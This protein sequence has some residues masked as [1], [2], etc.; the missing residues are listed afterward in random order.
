MLFSETCEILLTNEV[1]LNSRKCQTEKNMRLLGFV[2]IFLLGFP[3]AANEVWNITGNGNFAIEFNDK[4]VHH[5][6]VVDFF[7]RFERVVRRVGRIEESVAGRSLLLIV[8]EKQPSGSCKFAHSRKHRKQVLLLPRDCK[9]LLD[10]PAAGRIIA[11]ALIQSRLG[12][13]PQEPLPAGANWIA[14]GLWAE[15]VQREV[16]GQRVMRFIWLPEL[17]NFVENGGKLHFSSKIL[18]A[19]ENIRPGSAEWTFYC[20]KARL[21][22]ELA[23][24]LGSSSSNL[25]KDYCFLLFARQLSNAECFEQTF[26]S[27]ARRKLFTPLTPQ[28][29]VPED[30]KKAAEYAL[31]RLAV[32]KLYSQYVPMNPGA[33]SAVFEKFCHISFMQNKNMKAD[34]SITDLPL[35]AEKYADCTKLPRIK[36]FELNELTA[37]A[38]AQLRNDFFKLSYQLGQ[39]GSADP[40]VISSAMKNIIASLKR[41]LDELILVDAVLSSMETS[42]LPLLYEQRFFMSENLRQSPLPGNIKSFWDT[43][44]R[45][46]QK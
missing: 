40:E 5:V 34:A 35:L 14:D 20:Q 29:I 30:G 23:Q 42:R 28:E 26:G 41:K 9:S 2:T 13:L 1:I 12:N 31:N 10:S 7:R 25:L 21:M 43:V 38:P 18:T 22:L 4:N 19:P 33:V 39:I 11:S 46:L 36:I 15:F 27:A 37:V 16:L 44:E 17:R 3:I 6:P 8:D 32:K 45:S 24:S